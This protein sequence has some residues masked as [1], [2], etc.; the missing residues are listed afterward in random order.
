MTPF[1]NVFRV[2]HFQGD[3]VDAQSIGGAA[4]GAVRGRVVNDDLGV[5]LAA[6]FAGIRADISAR[7]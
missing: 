6:P 2:A 1:W 7:M 4:Q 3:G 5:L